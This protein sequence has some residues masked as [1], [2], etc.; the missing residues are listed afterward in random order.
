MKGGSDLPA[1][2]VELQTTANDVDLSSAVA[3]VH[4]ACGTEVSVLQHADKPCVEFTV[5]AEDERQAA[6]AAGW[7]CRA[8]TQAAPSLVGGWVLLSLLAG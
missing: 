3:V 6:A 5:E 2:R 7:A 4:A 1:F 8:L